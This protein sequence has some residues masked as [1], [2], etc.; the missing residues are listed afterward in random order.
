MNRKKF[1]KSKI[2]S[3]PPLHIYDRKCIQKYCFIEVK[4]FL[5]VVIN[6]NKGNILILRRYIFIYLFLNRMNSS[7]S[8]PNKIKDDSELILPSTKK[9]VFRQ[10]SLR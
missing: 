7:K 5:K 1:R 3:Q 6:L 8:E 9:Q 10:D 4:I 2:A